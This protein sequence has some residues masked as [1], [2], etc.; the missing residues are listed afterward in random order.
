MKA[1]R[2]WL[3]Q[4]AKLGFL[5]LMGA[6]MSAEAGLFGLGGTEKW[7]E[8]VQMSDGQLIVIE[9]EQI[10][11]GGGDE[12]AFNRSGTKPKEFRIRFEYP[13]GLRKEV[14]WKSTKKSPRT[15]PEVPLVFDVVAS[16]PIVFTLVAI[17]P[18][19]E[20]YSKYI[21]RDGVGWKI[22]CP[23]SLSRVRPTCSSAIARACRLSSIWRRRTNGIPAVAT[24]LR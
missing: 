21:Y 15:W 18:A 20:I 6:S 19:C 12:W 16:Q 23:I 5:L 8:E 14:E 2:Q 17:S 22:R 24:D 9:R 13:K 7:R 1:K 4:M 10:N 3:K 11:E